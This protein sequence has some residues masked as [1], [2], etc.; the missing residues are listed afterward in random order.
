MIEPHLPPPDKAEP[1]EPGAP[2]GLEYHLL[3]RGARPGIWR[4]IVGVLLLAAWLVVFASVVLAVPFLVYAVASGQDVSAYWTRLVDTDNPTPLSLGYLNVVLASAI[5]MVF[6]I[7]WLLHG[8]RPG[9][10]T[11]VQPRMRWRFFSVCLGLALL[12]LIAAIVVSAMTPQEAADGAEITGK[13]NP[14]TSTTRDFALVI[15]FLTP[16][17]AAGEE[18]L[19]RG[20]LTQA[21]GGLFGR[22]W[23][24]VVVPAVLFA[25]AH[26]LGQSMPVF[27]D[28]LAFGLVAGV[29]V[30]LTGGLEAGIAMHV[31]NNFVAFGLALAFGDM[32]SA[33]NPTE[34]S[35]WTIPS[36]L[37]Q[38][39][40]YLGLAYAAAR[41]M[42]L[43]T[44]AGPSVLEAPPGRV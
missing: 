14:W 17:Q 31:L 7:S 35:W 26:G 4:P 25:L 41:A 2:L 36:T 8:M 30:I 21:F 18:Y 9:L 28:R 11:S 1:P 19:F 16:F 13:L 44:T 10:V 12:A 40:V 27:F 22:R 32:A 34:G 6:L 5:G 20:Y 33:L 39:L 42:G 23:V 37:A 24:A 29:L 38:S 43:R 3:Q 15:L